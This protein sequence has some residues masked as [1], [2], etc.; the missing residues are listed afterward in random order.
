TFRDMTAIRFEYPKFLAENCTGCA[1][2]WTQCPDSAI[3]GL[4]VK[5]PDIIKAAARRIAP[6][7]GTA[8]I[9]KVAPKVE[10]AIR[11][12]LKTVKEG[13]IPVTVMAE[14]IRELAAKTEDKE[15]AV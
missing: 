6:E 9:T 3:P 12:K 5:V 13:A 1:K 7:N 10:E 8:A 15:L 2:C 14:A 11:A 4:V